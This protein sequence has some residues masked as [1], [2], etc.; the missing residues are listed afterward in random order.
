MSVA[1]HPFN[2]KVTPLA[3]DF[4]AVVSE[5]EYRQPL[6]TGVAEQL[7]QLLLNYQV[8]CLRSVSLSAYEFDRLGRIFGEPQIQLL[9]EHRHP[10][11]ETVSVFDSTYKTKQ[12]KP[13]DLNLDRRSGWHTDDSY[14]QTPAKIT[15]LQALAIPSSGGQTKFCDARRAYETLPADKQEY[16]AGLRAIH[17]YDTQRAPARAVTRTAAEA[18]ET[19][20]VMHPLIRTHD[21]TRRKAIYFN[22]NR[23]DRID[24][25]ARD[26]SD[27]ILDDIHRHM[28]QVDFQYHHH[29][30]IGD[31]LVWDN[32]SVTHSVNMDFPVGETRIHQRLLLS[33]GTPL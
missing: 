25:L 11:C 18:A 9:R 10:E 29:W 17:S 1:E 7:N 21:E 22:S 33:G 13:H 8:L 32:R 4:G 3:N 23:T 24:G 28:T 2:I 27:R 16:F 31:I 12:S 30:Q 20:D 15:L 14:F 5:V 6:S 26:E 19:P